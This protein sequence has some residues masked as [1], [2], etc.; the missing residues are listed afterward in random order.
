[1][2]LVCDNTNVRGKELDDVVEKLKILT[3]YELKA[4]LKISILDIRNVLDQAVP[5]VGCRRSVERLF[6]QI[7]RSG[8]PTLD[9]IVIT[10]GGIL[11]IREDKMKNANV[12]CNL[13]HGHA[14]RLNNLVDSQPRSKKSRRCLLH[15]L[16]SQRPR[17]VTPAWRDVWDCMRAQ[18]KDEVVLIE[19]SSLHAT[20]E[21]YLRKHRFCGEC[22][23]KVLRAYTLLVEEP[24]PCKEKG[25]VASLYSGNYYIIP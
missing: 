8:F 23:T 24:D 21:N 9:P 19:A 20:L 16:E 3:P 1:M 15:S 7:L 5:C 18:C 13:F 10:K 4:A 14:T 2:G 6:F 22:R 12:L 17:P 11:T 25:Y